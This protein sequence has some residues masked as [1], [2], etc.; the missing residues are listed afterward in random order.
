MNQQ[1]WACV[2]RLGGFG[3]NIIAS[4][5]F[6]GLRKKYGRLE[7]IGSRPMHILYENNPHIDKLTVMEPGE[8]PWGN[9]H[10]WQQWFYRRSREGYAFFANLAHSCES[11]G[12]AMKA[13]TKFWWSDRMRRQ[14]MSRSYLELAHDICDVPYSE[15]SPNVYPTE[16]E[17]A[18]A[19][20]T[21]AKVGAKVVGWVLTG[22][23]IDKIHPQADVAIARVIR[24]LN[25]PVIMFGAPGKDYEM[26]KL[27][28]HETRKL[29]HSEDGLHLALSHDAENPTWGPRRICAQ[30]QACD[31]VVGPDT[32][33]M[34]AVAMHAMPKV[35]MASHAGGPNITTHWVN[36]TTLEA[37]RERVPCYPCH[38][39]HDDASMC[40]PNADKNG[41]ACI[42]DITVDTILETIQKSLQAK[43]EPSNARVMEAFTA[44]ER[45]NLHAAVATHPH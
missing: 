6:K 24:E 35:L 44:M 42:S 38:R 45:A 28:Q 29:N 7:V 37:D 8:P 19:I 39:L 30:A 18:Q 13:E 41:S 21:K 36:T 25:L 15:I 14:M 4:S 22:S 20:A 9:G 3:D 43:N 5:V 27:V 33:P 26:A 34:W 1:G 31:I 23:R 11:L 2:A 40:K 17:Q 16:E 12:V 32:G 10:E